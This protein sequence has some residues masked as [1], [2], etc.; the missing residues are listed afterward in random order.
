MQDNSVAL[1]YNNEIYLSDSNSYIDMD[2]NLQSGLNNLGVFG[3]INSIE[4]LDES[5]EGVSLGDFDRDGLDEVVTIGDN[6]LDIK[7]QNDTSID[8]FPIQ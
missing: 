6:Y 1:V 7:N 4:V 2:G 8:Y 3:Y 5:L